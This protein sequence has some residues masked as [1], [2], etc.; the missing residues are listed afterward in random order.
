MIVT[1]ATTLTGV[2]IG[3]AMYPIAASTATVPNYGFIQTKGPI[4]VLGSDTSAIGTEIMVPV[5]GTAGATQAY[6][7]G[8]GANVIGTQWIVAAS[9]H[10]SLVNL[11]L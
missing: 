9:A 6:V 4:A 5:S 2:P 1:P 10:Y 7:V 11:Q 8:S 3:V